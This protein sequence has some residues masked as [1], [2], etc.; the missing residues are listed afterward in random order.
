MPQVVD[1]RKIKK[2]P[3][4]TPK[5]GEIEPVKKIKHIKVGAGTPTKIEWTALEFK[6]YKKGKKWFVFPALLALAVIIAAILLKNLLLVIATILTV[7]VVYIY[8]KKEPRKIKFSISGNGVQIDQIVYKFEDLKSF[9]IF[10]EP[11]SPAG[12]PPEVKEISI[13]S[14]KA[15]MPYIKIPLN[16]QNPAEIRRLLLKFL[17]E[18]K[19]KESV[20]DEWTRR[21]GF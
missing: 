8:A 19:H 18:K 15:F 2:V 14:K 13:R 4:K 3:K 9:W 1:L 6:K 10:Y 16:D 7:F 21:S 5:K 12:G 17:P 20:I 11:A